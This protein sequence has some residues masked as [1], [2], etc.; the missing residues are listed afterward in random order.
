MRGREVAVGG[1]R[2]GSGLEQLHKGG[3]YEVEGM[4]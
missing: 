2:D 4:G 1:V 3:V